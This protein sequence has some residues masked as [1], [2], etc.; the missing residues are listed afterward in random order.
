MDQLSTMFDM[1]KKFQEQLYGPDWVKYDYKAK[2]AYLKNQAVYVNNEL[3]EMFQELP[4]FKDWKDYD[5]LSESD[6]AIALHIAKE[7]YVDAWHFM[8][9]IALGLGF[10]AEEL[11]TM[12]LQKHGINLKRQEDGYH[13]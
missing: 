12:Y 4:Y 9:N 7:E 1:Q 3:G 5:C 2:A 11:H 8:V 13:A 10:T 6:L